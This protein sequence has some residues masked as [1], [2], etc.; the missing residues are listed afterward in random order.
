M[1]STDQRPDVSPEDIERANAALQVL[2]GEWLA[3]SV[4][5][6]TAFEE[7]FASTLPGIVKT[8][9]VGVEAGVIEATPEQR[10]AL[11]L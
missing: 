7:L 10:E 9:R 5:I 3:A 6:V 11:G 2:A 8:L 4:S 1:Q